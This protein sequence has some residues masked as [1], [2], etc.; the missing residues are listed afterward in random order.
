[1]SVFFMDGPFTLNSCSFAVILMRL[2]L[3]SVYEISVSAETAGGG[4]GAESEVVAV[5]TGKFGE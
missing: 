3:N 1:M 2:R 5:E 4:E